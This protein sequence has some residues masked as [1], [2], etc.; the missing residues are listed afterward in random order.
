MQAN[1]L[2]AGVGLRNQLNPAISLKDGGYA[3]AHQIMII[4]R[5]NADWPGQLQFT[6]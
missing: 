2:C 1:G 5:K 4:N 6:L 3:F